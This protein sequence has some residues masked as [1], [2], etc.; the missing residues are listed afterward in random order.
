MRK[1]S[2]ASIG[3]LGFA[4]AWN[5]QAQSVASFA[6]VAG[7]WRGHGR[8][9]GI[10]T[11]IVIGRNGSWTTSSKIGTE[12]GQGSIKDGAFLIEWTGGRG[13]MQVTRAGADAITGKARFYNGSRWVNGQV[14]ATRCA[15]PDCTD[16]GPK[17]Y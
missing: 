5:A 2:L 15:K 11:T 4:L 1:A 6:D 14:D 16:K 8:Q 17:D 7:S 9:S 3:L 12:S 13:N 10:D